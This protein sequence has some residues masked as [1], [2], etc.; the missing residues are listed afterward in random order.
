MAASGKPQKVYSYLPL[1]PCLIDLFRNPAIAETLQYRHNYQLKP[2][3]V[4][5]VFDGQ[6]YK[7]LCNTEVT[8]GGNPIGHKF[9]SQPTDLALGL[10]TDGFGPFKRR[11]HTCWPIIV[12]LYNFPPQIRT[13][14]GKIFCVGLIP[15]ITAPKD[16]DSYVLPIVDE[17]LELAKGVPAFFA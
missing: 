9:F 7:R 17:L 8:I 6:H 3:T 1:I 4:A 13:H 10:S 16:S 2:G 14:L 12:F 5:D 11:K 15:G